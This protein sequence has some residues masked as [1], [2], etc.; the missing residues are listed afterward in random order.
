MHHHVSGAPAHPARGDIGGFGSAVKAVF[1][2]LST[3]CPFLSSLSSGAR[4]PLAADAGFP[5]S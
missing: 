3:R 1:T 5:L 4:V 2:L